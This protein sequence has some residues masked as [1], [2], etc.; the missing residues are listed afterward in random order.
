MPGSLFSATVFVLG[1][2]LACNAQSSSSGSSPSQGSSSNP[3]SSQTASPTPSP[4]QTPAKDGDTKKPKKVWTNEDVS[5]LNGPVSTVGDESSAKKPEKGRG[6]DASANASAIA[7]LR[8]D[9]QKLRGALEQID[10]QISDLQN[11][12]SGAGT[13]TAALQMHRGYTTAAIP[14]QIKQ[15]EAKKRQIQGRIDTLEEEARKKGIEPGQ[16]R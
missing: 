12:S 15:L 6:A 5:G 7:R 9:L 4:T 3:A 1:A 16:L 11:F 14:D 13:G 8:S 10:K 2:A